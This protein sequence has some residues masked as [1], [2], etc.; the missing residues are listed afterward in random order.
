MR[1][2]YVFDGAEVALTDLVAQ[3]DAQGRVVDVETHRPNIDDVVA[4]LYERW[5]GDVT[6]Q[7]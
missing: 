2:E 7:P 4:E 6:G 3:A 5:Q 1:H